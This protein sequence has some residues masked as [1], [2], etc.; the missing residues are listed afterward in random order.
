MTP[1]LILAGRE[2]RAD[3]KLG[4]RGFRIF[5]ACLAIG[6]AAITASGNLAEAVK[7]GLAADARKLLGGDLSI[8]RM[9][10]PPSSE[11]QGFLSTFGRLSN[12]IEMRAMAKA[13]NGARTLVELKAVDQAYPLAGALVV[14]PASASTW[15]RPGETPAA[16]AD[17]N[18]LERLGIKTGDTVEL[19]GIRLKIA[20]V[21]QSEPD[22][23]AS[24]FQLGPRLMVSHESL[25]ASGLMLPGSIERFVTLVS[26]NAPQSAPELRREIESRF[27]A[28]RLRLRGLDEAAPGLKRFLDNLAL[29]LALTGMT[30]LL[31]G[32]I[33]IANAIDSQMDAKR[34]SIAVLKCIGASNRQI[35]A[36]FGLE[37]LCVSLL[38]ILAGLGLGAALPFLLQDAATGWLPVRLIPGLYPVSL[39]KAGLCGLLVVFTFGLPALLSARNA[40]PGAAMRAQ[41]LRESVKRRLT[42]YAYAGPPA[43]LLIGLVVQSS[44]NRPLAFW[45]S[46]GAVLSLVLFRLLAWG[47]AAMAGLARAHNQP[48]LLRLALGQFHR[49]ASPVPSIVVSLGIGLSVLTTL[50]QIES[51]LQDQ[52]ESRLPKEA[53]A[54]FFIDIQPG[55]MNAF[56]KAAESRGGRD[57]RTAPMI[58]GRV[59]AIN[60]MPA[61]QRPIDPSARWALEGDRGFSSAGKMPEGTELTDGQW[62]DAEYAGQAL[63]SVDAR[64]ARGLGIG[65]GDKVGV[66]I[67]GREIEA[68]V[69]SLREIDWS[70][71]NMNFA[72]LFSP[73]TLEGAPYTLLATAKADPGQEA[74]IENAVTD[75]LPN[76]SAIR[77]RNALESVAGVLK[78]AGAA[79]FVMAAATLPAGGLVLAGAVAASLRRRVY[80]SVVL[81]VLGADSRLLFKAY[82]L[83]FSLLGLCAALLSGAIGTLAAFAILKGLMHMSWRFLPGSSLLVLTFGFLATLLAGHLV[84]ASAGR[85]KAA[86]YLRNE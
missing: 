78:A 23:V 24:P 26:L 5:L 85:A 34:Q 46:L 56:L 68:E 86:P 80:E 40:S 14:E 82:L 41:I 66:E 2:I 62:W 31:V 49:P 67:L 52:L 69:S 53:P 75:L 79:L 39:L 61:Q 73:G 20:G 25:Q 74:A 33:G 70:A 29:F 10:R 21:I 77:V 13:E 16:L 76:V 35:V 83:E 51:N 55:Q 50:A 4:F 30:G 45:F 28:E 9:Y 22:K 1:S 36:A 81:K 48:V 17:A 6:V 3:L 38:G 59:A 64:L 60:G 12:Q 63:V 18:L 42:R 15:T 47:L 37:T 72:F 19:G 54:F 32:G 71:A 57:I 84:T 65:V 11:L 43:L 58:R 7:A 8:S 27:A 44:A